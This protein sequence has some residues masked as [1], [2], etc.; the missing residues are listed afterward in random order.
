MAN[1]VY[2]N[3]MEVSCK[4]AAG[5][6]ICAF[7]DVCFTPPQTPATPPGVPIPYP[8]TGL[9]SDTTSGSTSVTISG[10]EVML[11]NKSYF[12]KSTG[13]E[14]GCAPKKGITTSRN[15]GKVYFS[16][17]S[18]D[19]RVEGEN[20]VRHLDLTT[21]NHG[22]Y[23]SNTGPWPYLD[24]AA[25]G[26]GGACK[27][28]ADAERKACSNFEPHGPDNLCD[29]LL[30]V[31]YSVKPRYAASNK[32]SGSRSDGQAE[33]LAK[34]H[35]ASDCM[36]KR[37]CFLMPYRP[38]RGVQGCCPPQTGHH[39]IEASALFDV[40]RG[41]TGSRPLLGVTDYIDPASALRETYHEDNAPCV[42]AEG[43]N[44]NTGSHGWMHSFQSLSAMNMPNATP[45]LASGGTL[46]PQPMQTYKQAKTTAYTAMQKAF[47]KSRHC[48]QQC[49]EAQ[50]DNYH[51]KFGLTDTTMIKA[52][53]EGQTSPDAV[54]AAEAHLA[55]IAP[56]WLR[57]VTQTLANLARSLGRLLTWS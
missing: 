11:K 28:D 20:V 39:L 21:H 24:A 18:M 15:M 43:I 35:A 1:Q 26:P 56:G 33:L 53:V 5:K 2:A 17:W 48:T 40:G 49:I 25:V 41:G 14:A 47:P 34:H 46:P 30:P 38:K 44:Q 9:A 6:S 54:R 51:Q 16:A 27:T 45:T 55:E 31:P 19:V 12:K 42:C 37:R 52:V 57:T 29:S 50:I 23:P 8:N 13:D 7:P 32:P 10:Q 36:N 22:S 4:A 3:K